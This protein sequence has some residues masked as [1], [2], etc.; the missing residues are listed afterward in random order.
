MGRGVGNGSL[1]PVLSMQ[2]ATMSNKTVLNNN[3]SAYMRIY[4]YAMVYCDIFVLPNSVYRI[5]WPRNEWSK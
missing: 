1:M 4:G 3:N 5:A 2:H